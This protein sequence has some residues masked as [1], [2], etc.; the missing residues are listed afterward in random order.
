MRST[1]WLK[2]AV[3]LLFFA[4]GLHSLLLKAPTVDEQGFLVRGLGYV[5]G[6][7]DHMRVGHPLGLNAWNALLL[8]GD[9]SVRL[10][11]ADPSWAETSFHRPAELFL[12]EIGNNV[13]HIMALARVMTLF[14][15]MV[16]CAV[17]GRW[18]AEL[19]RNPWAGFFALALCALDP[20]ILAHSQLT[21]TDLGLALGA[22]VAGYT[23]WRYTQRPTLGRV[24]AFGAGLALLQNTKFTAVLFIPFFA[25]ILLRFW[26]LDFR[27]WRR[28][29]AP[30]AI[31]NPQSTIPLHLFAFLTT[32]FLALWAM[33]GFQISTLP[34]ELPTLPQLSGLTLPLAHH[35]EQLLDIGNRA[36]QGAP[37]FLMGEYRTT[38]WWSYFPLAFALK[39][40]LPT[41]VL[42][43]LATFALFKQGSRGAGEQASVQSAIR[44]PQSAISLL[45]PPVGYFA[46]ALTTSVNLGY[47]HLL[48]ILPFLFVFIAAVLWPGRGA[49]EQRSQGET[50]VSLLAF[51]FLLLTLLLRT[52]TL[53]P[54]FLSFFNVL[55]G[56]PDKGWH[57][58]VDSNLDWGQDLAQLRPWMAAHN[59]DQVW[60]SYFGEAR[61]AYYG[62]AY[63]GLDSF[64]PRHMLP[65]RNP[66]YAADPA[67]GIY[68]ISATNLQGVHFANHDQFAWFRAREPIAKIGYSIFLY[69]VP[70][71]GE[72][73]SLALPLGMDMSTLPPEFFA[74]LHTNDIR[75]SWY[76][77]GSSYLVP[78]HNGWLVQSQSKF[79]FPNTAVQLGHTALQDGV[80]NYQLMRVV[81]T[82]APPTTWLADFGVARLVAVDQVR[83][84]AA[85]NLL[86]TTWQT[87][88][89][90]DGR[91][92]KIFVHALDA[93]GNIIGQIDGLDVA[94]WQA[95]DWFAQSHTFAATSQPIHYRIGLYDS[96]T[97]QQLGEPVVVV[98]EE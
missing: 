55:A 8:R 63:K 43:L 7:N 11:T 71:H 89:A 58:L 13:E 17:V 40:P 69:D 41:L 6:E 95:G 85:E 3:L 62:I 28:T 48:P 68:A 18:A 84:T 37:S 46:I 22:A 10:P 47:R 67:P 80:M 14:L 39:T 82:P 30:S 12:W 61:P 44:N 57:Y 49:E 76:Q 88:A 59:V 31:Y 50:H 1:L 72:P 53:A 42:L 27:T 19:T 96:A 92:L 64:P 32:A 81:Q 87:T 2:T 97:G 93:N 98:S 66:L 20:N 73:A 34:T 78:A 54:D 24:I 90:D 86:Y 94:S 25:L 52:L 45:L 56:G 91:A 29:A 4:L 15:G 16:L 9:E 33:Y 35:L 51:H 26:F 5:R 65:G 21:T 83:H 70:A 79:F 60:L 23:L 38:G 75:P 74:A 77:S 36:Q